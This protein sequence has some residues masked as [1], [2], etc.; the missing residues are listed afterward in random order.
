[1]VIVAKFIGRGQ[2]N[3]AKDDEGTHVDCLD[4]KDDWLLTYRVEILA[5][6]GA[7]FS[8]SAAVWCDMNYEQLKFALK[9]HK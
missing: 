1:L 2:G 7:I 6:I 8:S 9:M 3:K 4:G 5:F